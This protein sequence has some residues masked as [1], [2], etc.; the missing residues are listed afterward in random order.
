MHVQ[1]ILEKAKKF[2]NCTYIQ[3]KMS[4]HKKIDPLLYF[5]L[6]GGLN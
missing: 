5:T 2:Q 1:R 4:E 6:L 3:L